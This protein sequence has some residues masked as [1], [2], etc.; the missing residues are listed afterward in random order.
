MMKSSIA[1]HS[2]ASPPA[3]PTAGPIVGI[4]KRPMSNIILYGY[5]II[6]LFIGGF[7]TDGSNRRRFLLP[8]QVRAG[9]LHSV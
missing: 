7:G 8:G 4:K 5:H 3:D 2:G 9:V 6:L 1:E